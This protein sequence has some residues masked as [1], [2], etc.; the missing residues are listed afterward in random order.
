MKR[1]E[2]RTFDPARLACSLHFLLFQPTVAAEKSDIYRLN[3]LFIESIECCPA[4]FKPSPTS[5]SPMS[6]TQLSIM[7]H[8]LAGGDDFLESQDLSGNVNSSPPLQVR[9][10]GSNAVVDAGGF[11][12]MLV[13][14]CSISRF[15]QSATPC[16]TPGSAILMR[17]RS[18]FSILE[19]IAKICSA[20]SLLMK[21]F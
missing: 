2:G 11:V 10:L 8:D 9:C 19:S 13:L 6:V 21:F 12:S 3:L 7:L 1:L 20:T 16:E 18:M 5:P 14:S 4:M 15:V 17:R